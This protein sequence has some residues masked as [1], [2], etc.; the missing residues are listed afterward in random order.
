MSIASRFEADNPAYADTRPYISADMAHGYSPAS[1]MPADRQA[2]IAARRAFVDMKQV[3]M[4]SV[5]ALVD[6]KGQW[7]R[8][9]VRLAQDPLDLWLLRGAVIEA[10]RGNDAAT[11]TL[12]AELYRSLDTVFPDTLLSMSPASPPLP[13]PWQI[14]AGRNATTMQRG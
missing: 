8:E 1:G 9:Q 2:H 11:R 4:R 6:R 3:F 7:L 5:A 13:A 14:W 12:R 10:L